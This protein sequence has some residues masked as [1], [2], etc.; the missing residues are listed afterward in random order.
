MMEAAL[1]MEFL[2]TYIGPDWKVVGYSVTD[3]VHHILL[4]GPKEL[5]ALSFKTLDKT[6]NGQAE[7]IGYEEAV[8]IE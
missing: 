8:F 1:N 4:Q 6:Q 5:R 7:V 2:H 3:D